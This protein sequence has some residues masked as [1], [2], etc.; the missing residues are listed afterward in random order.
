MSGKLFGLHAAKVSLFV[1]GACPHERAVHV[2]R[3]KPDRKRVCMAANYPLARES[4]SGAL[5][6]TERLTAAGRCECQI[7]RY[8]AARAEGKPLALL[9]TSMT[10]L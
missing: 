4:A 6:R 1:R 9:K 8:H 2:Q 10:K 7:W 5:I 3:K